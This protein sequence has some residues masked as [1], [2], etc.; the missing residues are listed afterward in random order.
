[1]LLHHAGGGRIDSLVA[2]PYG[3]SKADA[4]AYGHKTAADDTDPGRVMYQCGIISHKIGY[5]LIHR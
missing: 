5:N 3:D 2:P 4:A 1:M